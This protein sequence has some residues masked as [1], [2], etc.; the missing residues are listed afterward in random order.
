[1][2]ALDSTFLKYERIRPADEFRAV[3][4]SGQLGAIKFLG[5]SR[6]LTGYEV[7][8]LMQ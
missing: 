5:N 3:D 8:C 7:V 1:M 4:C 6:E 2:P